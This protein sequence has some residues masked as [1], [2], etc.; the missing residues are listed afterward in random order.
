ML[1]LKNNTLRLSRS[2]RFFRV[3]TLCALLLAAALFIRDLQPDPAPTSNALAPVDSGTPGTPIAC[4]EQALRDAVA[5]GGKYFLPCVDPIV[6]T[7][8]LI[9]DKRVMLEGASDQHAVISGGNTLN[10]MIRVIAWGNLSI[11]NIDIVE[12]QRIG[13]YLEQD[14]L[15][16]GAECRF[17]G[18][19]SPTTDGAAIWNKQGRV[20][21]TKCVI[22]GNLSQGWYA[23]IMGSHNSALIIQES[24]FRNNV[25]LTGGGAAISSEGQL[26]IWQSVFEGNE[27]GGGSII[28]IFGTAVIENSQ[29]INNTAHNG[30]TFYTDS[31]ARLTLRDTEVRGNQVNGYG[32]ILN[33]GE[34]VVERTTLDD[35]TAACYNW[36]GTIVDPDGACN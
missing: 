9:V 29:I 14:S 27:A 16:F 25:S 34:F 21:L 1:K 26:E 2:E 32:S 19:G 33:R 30:A 20:I 8:P 10:T 11:F 17:A 24:I 4:T 18:H 12:S 35:S 15:F 13:L 7:E 6:L 31:Y 36:D 23:G 28:S 3:V 5:A 22:E